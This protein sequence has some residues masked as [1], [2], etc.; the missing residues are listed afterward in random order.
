MT[1]TFMIDVTAPPIPEPGTSCNGKQSKRYLSIQNAWDDCL[2]EPKCT[3]VYDGSC[4]ND[5]FRLCYGLS[6]QSSSSC[7]YPHDV[8]REPW[9]LSNSKNK[10]K[11]I[12]GS[13]TLR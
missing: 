8:N 7:F 11:I 6:R 9:I 4:D 3:G 12:S 10:T 1:F 2:N 13:V 5:N